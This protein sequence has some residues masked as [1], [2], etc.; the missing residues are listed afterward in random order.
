[1]DTVA[2]SSKPQAHLQVDWAEIG[3][4]IG[5]LRMAAGLSA[6]EAA[7]QARVSR[8][9]WTE[10]EAGLKRKPTD[11]A[12][13]RVARVL[14]ID[15]VE[16]MARCRRPYADIPTLRHVAPVGAPMSLLQLLEADGRL[17]EKSRR[18]LVELYE[19]LASR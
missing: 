7:R 16:M 4:W 13:V 2:G 5:E 14:G 11:E 8:T 18:L 6:A 10:L 1:M 12:L 15:P 17:D 9:T 19:A 3:A